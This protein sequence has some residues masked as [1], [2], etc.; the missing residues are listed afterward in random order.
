M[1]KIEICENLKKST[2]KILLFDGDNFTGSSGTGVVINDAGTLL[3][4]NHVVAPCTKLTNPRFFA[5]GIGEISKIEYKVQLFNASIDINMPD[6][7]KPLL[8]DLAVLEPTKKIKEHPYI[9]L[10]NELS[11]E[12]SDVI[13]AGFPDEI[14]PPLNFNKMLNFN[15][16]DLDKEKDKIETFFES[17][18][19]L[20]MIKSGMIG[21]VQK[22][23][24]SGNS[25]ISGLEK[26][27]TANGAVYWVDNGSNHGASGGPVVDTSGKLIGIICEKGLTNQ[28]ITQDTGIKVPSGA[29]MAL[30]HKLITWALK[31]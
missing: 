27:F 4:A 8:I 13:M 6:F 25:K 16:S 2:K 17:F 15:N 14:K 7:T 1:N 23:N 22:T 28:M 31:N 19:C 10:N 21:S 5:Y 30:S 20:I 3:T 24:I 11:I 12:G 26:S 18:M 29:T 9:E